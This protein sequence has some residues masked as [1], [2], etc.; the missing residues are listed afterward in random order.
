MAAVMA[1]YGRNDLRNIRR[2]T[3]LIGVSLGPLGYALAMW[4]V[5]A[6]TR[7]LDQQ[8]NFD[9][10][11]YHTIIISG[12]VLIAPCAVLGFICAMIL[13]EE[14]DQRTLAA[15]RVT[16][17]PPMSYPLYRAVT[18]T[19]A[20]AVSLTVALWLTFLVPADLII[21]AIPVTLLCGMNATLIGLMLAALARNKVEGMALVRG[22]GGV[23]VGLPL[24]PYFFDDNPFMLL[25][26]LL[27]TYWP[28]K[29][30]WE[31]AD[32]GTMWPYI[33]IGAGYCGLL[34]WWF[35]RRLGHQKY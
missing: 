22:L 5:P 32:G 30:Y 13:I 18:T 14:K 1:A 19:L 8:H 21:A 6:L 29:A 10:L 28:A 9:L 16:P 3:L 33:L 2:D 27:P 7:Y 20:T 17:A 26:G 4:F 15:L 12:F 34:C 31:A 35:L 25:F 11:P 23:L 24:I